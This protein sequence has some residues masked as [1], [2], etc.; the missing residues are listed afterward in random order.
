MVQQIYYA[1][2][3]RTIKEVAW[4]Q[5]KASADVPTIGYGPLSTGFNL[6]LF[7]MQ[8]I[9]YSINALLILGWAVALAKGV[10]NLRLPRL[11]G[12]ERTISATSKVVAVLLP[13]VLIGS[14]FAVMHNVNAYLALNMLLSR[15]MVPR[16]LETSTSV[17]TARSGRPRA[18]K[19]KIDKVLLL[20]FSIAFVILAAFEVTIVCFELADSQSARFLAQQAQPDYSTAS[21]VTTILLFMPGVTQSLVA[22]LLFGTTAHFRKRYRDFFHAAV[23]VRR[24]R[25]S[26]S[27]TE[28]GTNVWE[29]L[30]S[31]RPISGYR[32]TVESVELSDPRKSWKAN[33]S[34]SVRHD[35]P[36]QGGTA[37]R[38]ESKEVAQP[39]RV[40]GRPGR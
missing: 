32:C 14:S 13:P 4:K 19:I 7:E 30:D 34:V 26:V 10:Y 35:A 24:R 6:A 18:A 40:L 36:G 38:P 15:W 12:W 11:L 16:S 29:T 28:S 1:C 21:A 23:R 3:W 20:R 5:A 33:T 39:W 2:E 22:F 27:R 17:S 9:T 25:P 37:A 8:W 31:G